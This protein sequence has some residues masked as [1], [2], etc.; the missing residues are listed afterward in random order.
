MNCEECLERLHPFLDRELTATELG[1]VRVHLQDCGGCDSAFVLERVFL[2][3]VRGSAT[4]EVA[5]PGVRE[6]LVLRLRSD[7]R[8]SS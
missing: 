6:R 2:D 7:I 4:S 3:R 1:E 5:P 8:R